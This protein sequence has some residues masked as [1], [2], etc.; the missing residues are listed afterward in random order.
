MR[1]QC[2]VRLRR[3]PLHDMLPF[4]ELAIQA[5]EHVDEP[6]LLGACFRDVAATFA[7]AGR[8]ERARFYFDL[9][10]QTFQQ[11]GNRAGQANVYRNMAHRLVMDP[12]ERIALLRESVAI[13]RELDDQPIL[14]TMRHG[15]ADVLWRNGRFDEELP[16]LAEC[17]SITASLPA[18]AYLAPYVLAARA[19]ALAGSGRLEE[20]ADD[21]GRALEL[22]RREGRPRRH[23][24]RRDHR[25]GQ[26]EARG[27][28]RQ[29]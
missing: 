11:T 14:A 24:R 23:R 8:P 19:A 4:S 16:V 17:A 26:G 18:L 1:G 10:A 27:P 21:A 25:P 6:D 22:L 28:Y 3:Y 9:A 7:R 5:A 29:R 20:S 15:L 2:D 13:A 12:Q